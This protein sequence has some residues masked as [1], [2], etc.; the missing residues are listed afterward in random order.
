MPITSFK[1]KKKKK[2]S[3]ETYFFFKISLFFPALSTGDNKSSLN[4]FFLD[5]Y[6]HFMS[7]FGYLLYLD[8]I[9]HHQLTEHEKNKWI[10][11]SKSLAVFEGRYWHLKFDISGFSIQILCKLLHFSSLQLNPTTH[12]CLP[13]I[14][15]SRQPSGL[16][17]YANLIS[18]LSVPNECISVCGTGPYMKIISV[19]TAYV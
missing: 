15:D 1:K 17:G 14:P 11:K 7:F 13:H 3:W 16:L 4:T 8:W 6:L 12:T 5:I 19:T 9:C 10:K 2:N 18:M